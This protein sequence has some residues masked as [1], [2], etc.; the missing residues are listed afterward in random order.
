VLYTLLYMSERTQIYLTSE[1]RRRLDE[2][3][4][5]QGKSLA[6]VIREAVEAYV[7][8]TLPESEEA[9]AATF[10]AAPDIEVPPRDEWD[11]EEDRG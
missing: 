11:R 6:Q 2:I 8:T 5:R 3:A 10:G 7:I 1:Q 4:S 9:L